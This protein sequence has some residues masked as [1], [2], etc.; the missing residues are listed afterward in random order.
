MKQNL[1]KDG[2]APAASRVA[3]EVA[4]ACAVLAPTVLSLCQR[5]RGRA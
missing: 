3:A 5:E 2:C 4:A 1:L